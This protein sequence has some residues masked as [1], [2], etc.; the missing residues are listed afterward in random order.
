MRMDV[1]RSILDIYDFKKNLDAFYEAAKKIS[2]SSS[3]V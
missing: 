1:D 2:N 3:Y